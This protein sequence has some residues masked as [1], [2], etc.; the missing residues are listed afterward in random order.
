MV[1][2]CEIWYIKRKANN[3]LAMENEQHE[4]PVSITPIIIQVLDQ[5]AIIA[6]LVPSD[7]RDIERVSNALIEEGW[8]FENM[9]DGILILRPEVD[10]L[11]QKEIVNFV[12]SKL[13]K[14]LDNKKSEKSKKRGDEMKI[15]KELGKIS[16]VDYVV[17]LD[18]MGEEIDSAGNPDKSVK[19]EEL[20]TQ[21]S[22]IYSTSV[23]SGKK[24][25]KGAV[26]EIVVMWEDGVSVL[27]HLPKNCV[28]H[29]ITSKESLSS[30]RLKIKEIY[31]ENP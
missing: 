18:D 25:K 14:G 9:D 11:E 17:V 1:K 22:L 7:A 26:G 23:Q 10:T 6:V 12:Q 19:K 8:H 15:A 31:E 24:L 5:L 20:L 13:I 2:I 21:T 3:E 16:G 27:K 29:V 30:V 4:S 28:L